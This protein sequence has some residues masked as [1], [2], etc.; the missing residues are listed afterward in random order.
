MFRKLHALFLFACLGCFSL[1]AQSQSSDVTMYLLQQVQNND[2]NPTDIANYK[3]TSQH[4]SSQSGILHI[5]YW[6]RK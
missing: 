1:N 5:Y 6:H 4:T 3:I 2:L